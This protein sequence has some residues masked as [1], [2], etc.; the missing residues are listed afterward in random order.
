[1]H[2]KSL[3]AGLCLWALSA[4]ALAVPAATLTHLERE[5]VTN[6]A[7]DVDIWLRVTAG[8]TLDFN[9]TSGFLPG[10]LSEFAVIDTIA[11]TA[12]ATCAG[13]FWPQAPLSSCYDAAA[14]WRFNFNTDFA[15]SWE[16]LNGMTLA[17]GESADFLI[18][19]FSPQNGTVA[20]GL[21]SARN[22]SLELYVTGTEA[23]GAPLQRWFTLADSC[24]A[25]DERCAFTRTVTAVPE[26]ATAALLP[27]GLG[28]LAWHRRRRCAQPAR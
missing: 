25:V 26:P 2:R 15:T 13:T 6:G 10:E 27:L 22:F 7:V 18:G 17:A 8:E 20:P 12:S 16:R 24:A 19:R 5:A 4:T 1:M 21:Y 14:P 28:L 23:S 9:G 11:P 3:L